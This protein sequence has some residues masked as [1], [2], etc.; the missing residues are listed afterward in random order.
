M[1][2]IS[3]PNYAEALSRAERRKVEEE[4]IIDG[5]IEFAAFTALDDLFDRRGEVEAIKTLNQYLL[6]R[7][8]ARIVRTR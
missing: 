3:R 8:V 5:Y 4:E 2:V 6:D 1:N 7:R